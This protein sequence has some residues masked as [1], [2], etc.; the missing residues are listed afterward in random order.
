LSAIDLQITSELEK[1]PGPEVPIYLISGKKCVNP[2][3]SV[4]VYSQDPDFT[5]D[6]LAME[7]KG[8]HPRRSSKVI[9]IQSQK[10]E[11]S[12][13]GSTDE[14]KNFYSD[15]SSDLRQMATQ[16]STSSL[17]GPKSTN[18]F[19]GPKSKK[20][21]NLLAGQSDRSSSKCVFLIFSHFNVRC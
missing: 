16:K 7:G 2:L 6:L 3:A 12:R 17:N 21:N 20:K 13:F 11:F 18:S 1:L 4:K 10:K 14:L 15:S 8:I 9:A 19:V 5:I